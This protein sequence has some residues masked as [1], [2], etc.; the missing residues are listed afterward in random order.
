[1]WAGPACAGSASL[2][3]LL[4]KDK[5]NRPAAPESFETVKAA[6]YFLICGQAQT[7]F[8]DHGTQQIAWHSG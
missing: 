6:P 3:H 4:R 2:C 5:S 7:S 8:L 1:M